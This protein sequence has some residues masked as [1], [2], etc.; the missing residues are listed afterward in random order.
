VT[1]VFGTTASLSQHFH[2]SNVPLDFTT[3]QKIG[4]VH[5]PVRQDLSQKVTSISTIVLIRRHSA[6]LRV[7]LEQD[8]TDTDWTAQLVKLTIVANVPLTK[9]ATASCLIVQNVEL[10]ST[11]R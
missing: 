2:V 8:G 7:H 6:C 3:S 9:A 5:H 10:G 1:G 4:H 11:F